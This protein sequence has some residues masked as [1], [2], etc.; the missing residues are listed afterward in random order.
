M[1]W[2]AVKLRDEELVQRLVRRVL[3]RLVPL[4]PI[5]NEFADE[6]FETIQ[7]LGGDLARSRMASGLVDYCNNAL[8]ELL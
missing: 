4:R 8:E 3:P 7:L 2:R 5:A 6:L 1:Q